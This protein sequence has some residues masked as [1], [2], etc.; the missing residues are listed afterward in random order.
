MY[1]K[2]FINDFSRLGEIIRES[3]S[4]GIENSFLKEAVTLSCKNNYLFTPNMVGYALKYISE[5]YL[6][7]EKLTAWLSCYPVTG[8]ARPGKAGIVMA[9]NIPLVGFHDF[10]S[11]MASGHRAEIKLSSKDPYLLPALSKELCRISGFWKE[12]ITFADRIEKDI[13]CMLITGGSQALSHFRE[14][15]ASVPRIER[16]SRSSLAVLDGNE[17]LEELSLLSEDIFLYYGMG[18]RS[19]SFLLLPQGYDVKELIAPLSVFSHELQ[20]EDFR[21]AYRY[22]KALLLSEGADFTDGGFFILRNSSSFPPP[23]GVVNYSYYTKRDD[24]KNIIEIN[25]DKLQCIVGNHLP[26]CNITFG[27]GQKPSL[28]D[29]ADGIDTLNFLMNFD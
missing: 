7:C 24:A 16:S 27:S 26:F 6:N 13:V 5:S 18:C 9:G 22:R 12:R 15:Y 3:L 11:V 29:Y 1:G 19:V 28:G 17:S 23:L 8:V 10:L 21:Q 25:R 4:S 2:E 14:E 20:S